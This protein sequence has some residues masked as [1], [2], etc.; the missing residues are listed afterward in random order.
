MR[1]TPGSLTTERGGSGG[2]TTDMMTGTDTVIEIGTDTEITTE[3]QGTG[4]LMI[5]MTGGATRER[6]DPERNT[7][8]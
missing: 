7:T 8:E 4:D 2:N 1:V 5:E 6:R 3:S